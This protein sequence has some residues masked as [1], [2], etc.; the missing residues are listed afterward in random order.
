MQ[1]RTCFRYT[2]RPLDPDPT[3]HRGAIRRLG[4]RT[5]NRSSISDQ[6]REVLSVCILADGFGAFRPQCMFAHLLSVN[7]D[8]SRWHNVEW[9]S[10]RRFRPGC[11]ASTRARVEAE[12]FDR[13]V[14]AAAVADWWTQCGQRLCTNGHQMLQDSM[15]LSTTTSGREHFRTWLLLRCLALDT[16]T[17]LLGP[18][19]G[20]PR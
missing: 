19:L 1:K 14:T 15:M 3:V 10:F 17:S 12:D 20:S 7:S 6:V 13:S 8:R 16:A 5:A 4:R 9:A 11:H 18:G 2:G